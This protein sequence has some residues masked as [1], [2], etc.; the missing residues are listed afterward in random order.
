MAFSDNTFC[1]KSEALGGRCEPPVVI[2]NQPDSKRTMKRTLQISNPQ[3]EADRE[4]QKIEIL[5]LQKFD[6]L[7]NEWE[8]Q[9]PGLSSTETNGRWVIQ[10]FGNSTTVN[11]PFEW[12]SVSVLACQSSLTYCLRS[13]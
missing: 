4:K 1:Y 11:D 13:L 5:Q 2:Q 12:L 6:R 8:I 3:N 10:D 7:M 9:P